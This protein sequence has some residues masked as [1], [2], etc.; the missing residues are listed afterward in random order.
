MKKHGDDGAARPAVPRAAALRVPQ[1]A[2]SSSR[3]LPSLEK[4]AVIVPEAETARGLAGIVPVDDI[5]KLGVHAGRLGSAVRLPPYP[6][7]FIRDL[8]HIPYPEPDRARHSA[9]A[10][11]GVSVAQAAYHVPAGS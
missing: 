9:D 5:L 4:T 7:D 11:C 3:Q 8:S 1:N 6:M 10:A 2:K